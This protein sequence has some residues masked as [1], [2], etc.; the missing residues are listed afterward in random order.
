MNESEKK[1]ETVGDIIKR[2][3]LEKNLSLK[4]IHQKTKIPLSF[5][6]AIEEARIPS[7]N[8]V[9]VK[10]LIKICCNF[11]GIDYKE[12]L[13]K[14]PIELK[15]ESPKI[16]SLFIE[17]KTD[18]RNLFSEKKVYIFL[19]IVI[20]IL[21]ASLFIK[22]TN[23]KQAT[24]LK[25]TDK[26]SSLST[27][28]PKTLEW[29]KEKA[30]SLVSPQIIK[31]RLYAKQDCWVKASVDRKVVFQGILKK[32][33]F[34]VWEAKESIELSLGN[35]GGIDLYIND[36]PFSTLGKPGQIIRKLIINQEGLKV[37]R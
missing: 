3:R 31:V 25:G 7:M 16:E 1:E 18:I 2:K 17:N 8:P 13:E 30:G 6:E 36:K 11:L 21:F 10:G 15:N 37:L 22:N 32:G 34:Q 23:K 4:D 14:L 29:P 28:L 5:L 27:P 24:F 20:I 33:R 12:I 26:Q 19:I 9:Y 35:A